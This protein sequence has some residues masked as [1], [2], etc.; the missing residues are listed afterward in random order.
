VRL[1]ATSGQSG[2]EAYAAHTARGDD[3]APGED[4]LSFR[5]GAGGDAGAAGSA[6]AASGG[7]LV[8]LA[9]PASSPMRKES[10]S[11][12]SAT[13]RRASSTVRELLTT[14]ADWP[15]EPLSSDAHDA[16][17]EALR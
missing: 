4:T 7:A 8:A 11:K 16:A 3:G 10:A 1:R 15:A 14:C 5:S 13:P 12:G 6:P 2:R 9:S 17:H